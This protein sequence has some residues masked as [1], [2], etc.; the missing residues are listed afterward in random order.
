MLNFS[1]YGYP[2]YTL[3]RT[4]RSNFDKKFKKL[5]IVRSALLLIGEPIG[6]A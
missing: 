4:N 2:I 3:V 5:Y 1:N 6:K